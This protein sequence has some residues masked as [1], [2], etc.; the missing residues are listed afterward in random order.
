MDNDA[1]LD[2]KK[3]IKENCPS[4]QDLAKS[5]PRQDIV[6]DSGLSEAMR[7]SEEAFKETIRNAE[8]FAKKKEQYNQDILNTL[9]QIEGNTANLITLINL[10]ESSKDQQGEIIE[11]VA[12]LLALAKEKDKVIV[13][14][15]YR[16]IMNKITTFTEDVETMATLVALG[17]TV[18][19]VLKS[20]V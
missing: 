6:I 16:K 2:I 17:T 20:K 15:K 10:I 19:N 13:E 11:I 5:I 18:F 8:S 9:K 3:I 12:E 4:I 14:G 7:N 1:N